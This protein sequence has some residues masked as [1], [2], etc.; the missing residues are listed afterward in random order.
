LGLFLSILRTIY[1]F[2]TGD[3]LTRGAGNNHLHLAVLK[4]VPS[5]EKQIKDLKK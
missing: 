1:L 2:P 3:P 4:R 5:K